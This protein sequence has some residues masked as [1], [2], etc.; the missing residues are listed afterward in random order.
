MAKNKR[1]S[2]TGKR[3]KYGNGGQVIGNSL[4]LL[5]DTALSTVGLSN[6]IT[7][8]SYKGKSAQD[9]SNISDVVSPIAQTVGTIGLNA[10]A[11]GAGTI[12]NTIGRTVNSRLNYQGGGNLITN[13]VQDFQYQPATSQITGKPIDWKE[14]DLALTSL[15][16]SGYVPYKLDPAL[17]SLE[18]KRLFASEG[19]VPDRLKPSKPGY[20]DVNGKLIKF[21]YGGPIT[22]SMNS[23][24]TNMLCAGGKMKYEMGGN[25]LTEEK[26][27]APELGGYFR[28]KRK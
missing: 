14:P 9:F 28:R 5:G 4:R 13:Q 3:I 7:D 26:I 25:M 11:P 16:D 15:S 10:I 6:V 17:L 18:E 21:Q 19:R 12:T 24:Y 22:N 27:E 1:T 8:D 20:Y 23:D 2:K